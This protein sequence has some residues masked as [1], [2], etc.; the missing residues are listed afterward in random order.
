ML[1]IDR[2]NF[3]AKKARE[4]GLTERIRSKRGRQPAF[5]TRQHLHN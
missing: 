2:I 1:D 3:L 4:E 5:S